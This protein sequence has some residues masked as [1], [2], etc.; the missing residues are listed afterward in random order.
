MGELRL[1]A[2][3]INE[4]RDIFGA[5][6]AQARTLRG[7]AQEHFSVPETPRRR[8]LWSKLRPVTRIDNEAPILPVNWP[9]PQDV[10]DLIAGRFVSPDRLVRCWR[11]L[12][13]WLHNLSWG[14]HSMSMDLGRVD[15]FE[16]DLARAGL[17]SELSLRRLF[18]SDPQIPLRPAPGM[19]TGYSRAAHVTATRDALSAIAERVSEPNRETVAGLVGFLVQFSAWSAAAPGA[20]RAAPDL[21]VVW[22]AGQ[23]TIERTT[24]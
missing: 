23:S 16:F 13:L 9:T 7:W 19:H 17:P 18:G 15:D 10:D 22:H 14:T 11:V 8:G 12:D 21:F 2:I 4:V 1:H 6:E 5:D 20:G 24:M 3:S